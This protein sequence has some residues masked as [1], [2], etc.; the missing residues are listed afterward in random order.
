MKI[1]H[2]ETQEDYDALLIKLEEQGY[3]W[4][5]GS[6]MRKTPNYWISH[7]SEMCV[8]VNCCGNIT[9]GK[10][11]G[12]E[13]SYQTPI[14]KYKAKVDEKM[15]FTKENVEIAIYH[16]LKET[17]DSILVDIVSDI[18]DMVETLD[19]TP[20]KVVVP[21]FVAEWIEWNKETGADLKIM[22]KSYRHYCD[23]IKSYS[24]GIYGKEAVQWYIDNPYKFIQAYEKGYIVEPDTVTEQR[25]TVV[26][27]DRYLVQLFM[28]R[29]DYRFVE[30]D[31]LWTW[32]PDAFQLTEA[33]IKAIDERYWTFAVPA[34][35]E[36]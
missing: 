20:E 8:M 15:K 34:K 30:F 31:E 11:S 22:L 16:H 28:G 17:E 10:K 32:E 5:S 4:N 25:Y 18:Y 26:I 35:E 33:E 7:K 2:T 23:N 36:E 9:Y 21:K 1:Y 19:D 24:E 27:A 14:I 13:L 29:T 12:L 6:V 3:E